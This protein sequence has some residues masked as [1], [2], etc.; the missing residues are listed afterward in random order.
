MTSARPATV[1]AA[2]ALALLAGCA[3]VE[4][5]STP[6]AT[7]ETPKMATSPHLFVLGIAQDAGYPQAGCKKACCQPAWSDPSLRR[8]VASLALVDPASKR[9]WLFDITPDF[10][11][12]HHALQRHLGS[13]PGWT[14]AGIFLTHAHIGHYTG[15]VHL[16]RE[17]MGNKATKVYA[18]P[19]MQKF[20]TDNGPWSQLVRLGNIALQPLT[21]DQAVELGGGLRVTPM[22]VPHRDEFTETAG[23]A[24]EG[25]ARK[26][27]FIPDIDKWHRWKRD[28]VEEVQ[29]ID[30]AFLDGTFYR[31]GELGSRDM[32]QIPHPFVEESIKRLEPLSKADRA[33]VHFIHLNHTNPLL[34]ADGPAVG[35]VHALGYEVARQGATF[36]L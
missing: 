3:G 25:K 20:L 22:L 21:P 12:Q 33:K 27:L 32:S 35:E 24:I 36:G 11:E 29:K 14:L 16:G 6:T 30:I 10:P 7:M 5:K 2:I 9:F 15:L 34:Q 4:V 18:L 28:I 26:A 19:R 1:L 31:D 23:F 17:V 13:A 8:T